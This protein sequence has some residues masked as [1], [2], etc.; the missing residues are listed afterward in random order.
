DGDN[1]SVNGGAAS[2]YAGR[3]H[4]GDGDNPPTADE[5]HRV[6]AEAFEAIFQSGDDPSLA[7]HDRHRGNADDKSSAGGNQNADADR[8]DD[9]A[10]DASR[11]D[12]LLRACIERIV[13]LAGDDQR[14]VQAMEK[15]RSAGRT[16]EEGEING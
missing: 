13:D 10:D 15:R 14:R 4:I 6:Y 1:N 8:S 12:D 5:A 9:D 3:S 7:G 2:A 11:A 16:L